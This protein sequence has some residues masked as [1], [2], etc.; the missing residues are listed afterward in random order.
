MIYYYGKPFS[1]KA[2]KKLQCLYFHD[3][4]PGRVL[5]NFLLGS[6]E[7]FACMTLTQHNPVCSWGYHKYTCMYWEAKL[8]L[9]SIETLNV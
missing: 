8:Y 1:K 5:N 7:G 6:W 3:L 9:F 4:K 2:G